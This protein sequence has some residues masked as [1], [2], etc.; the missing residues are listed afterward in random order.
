VNLTELRAMSSPITIVVSEMQ[1]CVYHFMQQSID[2]IFIWSKLKK[3]LTQLDLF[4]LTFV[5]SCT[6][7]KKLFFSEKKIVV[8][9]HSKNKQSH[10]LAPKNL[11]VAELVFKIQT[12]EMVKEKLNV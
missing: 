2:N 6:S 1:V 7:A 12:V 10:S 5:K 4:F 11:D 9:E 8:N 3:R